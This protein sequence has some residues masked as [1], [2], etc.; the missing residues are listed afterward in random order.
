MLPGPARP[1]P[2]TRRRAPRPRRAGRGLLRRVRPGPRQRPR[3]RGDWRGPARRQLAW[4]RAASLRGRLV[5]EGR[6][7][8]LGVVGGGAF[9]LGAGLGCLACLVQCLGWRPRPAR[10]RTPPPRRGAGAAT[11]PR[12]RGRRS[13]RC[14][15]RPWSRPRPARCWACSTRAVARVAASSA[16]AR[17]RA[18]SSAVSWASRAEPACAVAASSASTRR[19]TASVAAASASARWVVW[20]SAS[21]SASVRASWACSAQRRV[22]DAALLGIGQRPAGR[23][24]RVRPGAGR[25]PRPRCD[26]QGPV[27]QPLRLRRVCGRSARR[28]RGLRGLMRPVWWRLPRRRPG[29]GRRPWLLFRLRRAGWSGSPP[30]AARR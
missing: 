25:L 1:G 11:R 26:G 23:R 8:Q 2:R 18:F 3:P 21:R 9:G 16:S 13:G 19:R 22:F 24:W 20:V 7:G 14:A 15:R 29:A 4:S 28:A 10:G 30:R 12:P 5:L 27:R 17:V 6:G